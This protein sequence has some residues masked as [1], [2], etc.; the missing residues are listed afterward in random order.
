MSDINTFKD[1]LNNGK[2]G[3]ITGARRAIGKFRDVS[4]ED[5]GKMQTMANKFFDAEPTKAKGAK[6]PAAAKKAKAPREASATT[7]TPAA[8][9]TPKAAA[10]KPA[11]EVK[12]GSRRSSVTSAET[13]VENADRTLTTISRA[14]TELLR[15]GE[16]GIDV[17][18]ELQKAQRG[19]SAVLDGLVGTADSI[20]PAP[21][22]SPA[23][24]AQAHTSMPVMPGLGAG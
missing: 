6:A 19:I 1:N 20:A 18:V 17:N 24:V 3:A 14:T 7:E 12:K 21:T 23:P 9:K 2:Y 13:D 11:A 8:K 15:I 22:A 16:K 5:R 10:E 4:D